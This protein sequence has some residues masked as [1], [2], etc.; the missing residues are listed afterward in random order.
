MKLSGR[1]EWTLGTCTRVSEGP[2][3]ETYAVGVSMSTVVNDDQ[4]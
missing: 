1:K 4:P 3:N 2:M